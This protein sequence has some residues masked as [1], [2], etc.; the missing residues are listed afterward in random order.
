MSKATPLPRVVIADDDAAIRRLVE[1]ALEDLPIELVCCSDGG[2]AL[3]ALREAPARLVITDLMMPGISGWAL[4][5]QLADEPA[6]RGGAKLAVFSAGLN[7]QAKERLAGLP[8]WR[9]IDKPVSVMALA[10]LVSSAVADAPSAS[11]EASP[12]DVSH[13]TG[14]ASAVA[15]HFGGDAAL[16]RAFRAGCLAQF[17]DDLR[18]GDAAV[19]SAN[20]QQLRR[21]A[22]SLKSVLLLLGDDEASATA[23]RLEHAAEAGDWAAC[24]GPWQA[25]SS[26]LQRMIGSSG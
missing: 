9:L 26:T 10:D 15:T 12:L 23:R 7:A 16:Y 5:Q 14:E 1:L 17:P 25:L 19:A 8:V 4:L 20:A 11:A 18:E 22:H 6:L 24:R 21:V 3:A 13:P 2:A